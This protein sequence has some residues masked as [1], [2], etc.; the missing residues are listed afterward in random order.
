MNNTRD[1]TRPVEGGGL[2]GLAAG[3]LIGLG[4]R[5]RSLWLVFGDEKARFLTGF[6]SPLPCNCS[7]SGNR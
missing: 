6:L 7:V 2:I 5:D 1:G 3:G 4:G